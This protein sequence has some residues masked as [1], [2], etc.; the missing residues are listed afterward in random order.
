MA[1][2]Q[3]QSCVFWCALWL[4][5]AMYVSVAGAQTPPDCSTPRRAVE[6]WLDNLQEDNFRPHLASRCF[7]W[8]RAHISRDGS[9][10]GRTRK[11]K[12]VLDQRGLLLDPE[13]LP[14]VM[15]VPDE[16]LQGGRLVITTRLPELFL[17]RVGEEWLVSSISIAS[18]PSLYAET[19]AFDVESYVE[20]FP[21]WSK[22][23]L[24]PNIAVWQIL[25]LLLAILLGFVLRIIVARSVSRWGSKLIEKARGEVDPKIAQSSANP[26]GTLMMAAWLWW[27]FPL[28]RFGVRVNQIGTLALR[29]MAA[30]AAVLLVYRLVDLAA[31]VFARRAERT[32]TKLDDQIVPMLRKTVKVFVVIVGFIFVLQN[33]DIDVGSLL[34]GVSL[35]GLAFTLAAKDTVANLFGSVSIFA[36]QPFQIGDWIKVDGHEGVVEE[37]GMR[38]TRVRTF[39]DSVVTIPNS[40]VAGGAVDNFG[41]RRHRRCKATFGLT[42]DATPDQ[43]QAFVEGVR[44]ILAASEAVEQERVEV[45]FQ[46]FGDSA[47]EIMVYF[48][49]NVETWTE[50]LKARQNIYLEIMR[51]AQ[52]IG[53]G[54]AF[55]SQTLYVKRDDVVPGRSPTRDELRW[56][57]EGYGPKG[58]RSLP[59]SPRIAPEMVESEKGEGSAD[60]GE[61]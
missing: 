24:L 1:R 27:A 54:F 41:K 21:D 7:D 11:L 18:I 5:V 28:F 45:S 49:F 17:E 16:D 38:S 51:F 46:G 9:R 30:I 19:F 6:T 61:G 57:V 36:D 53:V 52:D 33:L 42:Y 4:S 10:E 50:E 25:G 32:E 29:V 60:D 3:L 58:E 59:D 20:S 23:E 15:D 55:P 47:L 31:D 37:V 56:A 48:F 22:A 43:I 14:D 40:I 12:A 39:Y 35:G 8:E 34:A 26:V 13:A 44:A 2:K